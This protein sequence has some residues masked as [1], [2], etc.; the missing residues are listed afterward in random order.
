MKRRIK[1]IVALMVLIFE[2]SSS[3]VVTMPY[4]TPQLL[5]VNILTSKSF[6][7]SSPVESRINILD[8]P[9]NQKLLGNIIVDPDFYTQH[10]GFFCLKVLQFEKTT[11]IPLRFRLGSL[12][13]CNKLEGK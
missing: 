11:K 10:L 7:F 3:Q 2:K 9:A 13:Y 4:T 1:F 6:L 12:E 5:K 8:K